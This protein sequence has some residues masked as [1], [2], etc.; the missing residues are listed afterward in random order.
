MK[1]L[2]W[3]FIMLC[4]LLIASQADAAKF[5]AFKYVYGGVN[6]VYMD[7]I[8]GNELVVG[9]ISCVVGAAYTECFELDDSGCSEDTS[10]PD[11]IAP[12]T[13]AGTKRWRIR[14]S[15]DKLYEDLNLNSFNLDFPTTPNISD[16]LDEDTMT[17]NSATK[18]A[19]QQSIK[20][21]VDTEVE[22]R[23]PAVS[24]TA[25]ECLSS[26]PPSPHAGQLECADTNNWNPGGRS[27]TANALYMYDGSNWIF[28]IDEDGN[29]GASS[30]M[31]QG[32]ITGLVDTHNLTTAEG[33]HDGSSG[34]AY[35]S[36]SGETWPTTDSYVGMTLYNVTDTS[37]CV[38]VSMTS[39]TMTC[40][41]VADDGT[42]DTEDCDWDTNDVW[43]V[44]P[45]PNQSAS[46]WRISSAT[47]ILHPNTA[48]YMACYRKN[49]SYTIS[50]DPQ[51]ASMEIEYDGSGIG[52]GDEM[53]SP[54]TGMAY[55]C[56]Q[57]VSTTSA[58]DW[59]TKGTWSD[60]GAS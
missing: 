48:K 30:I 43:K 9:D 10:K 52:A 42:C 13:N 27:G 59:G 3:I 60:G 44:A 20:A 46:T 1:K 41:L 4:S 57:N 28:I 21:Y 40:T 19:T 5:R 18:L 2:L 39:T 32:V 38:V 7:Y 16:V 37:H 33:Q 53:D 34:L 22:K 8:D 26:A 11:C 15:R 14:P 31:I 23:W 55:L 45:G 35:L 51:N 54:S 49:G 6:N 50:V 25:G 24:D 29:R 58:I 47:T 36:D 56:L 17:S 12:D